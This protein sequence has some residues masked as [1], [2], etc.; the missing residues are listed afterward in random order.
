M[1][2]GLIRLGGIVLS[3]GGVIAIGV[4]LSDRSANQEVICWSI[5]AIL[6]GLLLFATG[7]IIADLFGGQRKE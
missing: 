6:G 3:I 2:G 5:L 7:R 1:I 4:G